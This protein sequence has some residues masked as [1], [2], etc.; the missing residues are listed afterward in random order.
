MTPMEEKDKRPSD[1]QDASDMADDIARSVR[2]DKRTDDGLTKR[3]RS[4]EESKKAERI[5]KAKELKKQLRKKELGLVKYRWSLLI[6]VLGG[7][8]SISTEFLVVMVRPPEPSPGFDTFAGAFE[9]WGGIFFLFPLIAGVLMILCG[10]LA[11]SNPKFAW[12]SFVPGMMM[13]MS[14]MTTYFLISFG[15][16]ADPSAHF[17]ATGTPFT[18][19]LVALLS[20]LVV[21]LRNKE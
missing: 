19:L 3:E 14:G 9:K 17:S 1:D 18:M 2:E 7:L 12:L 21:L 5:R 15:M 20:V 10:F 4:I 16:A 8:L 13:A 6:L 11:Y